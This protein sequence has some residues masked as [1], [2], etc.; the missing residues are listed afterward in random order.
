MENNSFKILIVDDDDVI[1]ETYGQIFKQKGANVITAKDG[2][3]G[4]DM[5][6]KEL[7]DVIMTGIIMPRMDGFQLIR[8]LE[9]NTQTKEIPILVLSHLGREEDRVKAQEMGIDNFIVQGSMTPNEIFDHARNLTKNG[10]SFKLSFDTYA[11]DAPRLANTL[12]SKNFNCPSCQ[13]KIIIEITPQE[14]GGYTAVL[15]CPHCGYSLQ[16]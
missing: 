16:N 4:V 2:I 7:P 3:E 9:E 5:A 8:T 6:T 13:E 14:N 12:P 1:R 15:K 11:W 10:G